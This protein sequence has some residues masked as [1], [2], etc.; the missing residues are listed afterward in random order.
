M[1]F[2]LT[3][4]TCFKIYR[5]T[6]KHLAHIGVRGG[7]GSTKTA[8]NGSQYTSYLTRIRMLQ[9]KERYLTDCWP[10]GRLKIPLVLLV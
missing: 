9:A 5:S 8:R 2:P 4:M 6:G 1:Y 3:K 10:N 7:A